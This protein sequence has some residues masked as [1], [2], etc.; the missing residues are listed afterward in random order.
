MGEFEL[1]YQ[2]LVNL[3][4]KQK[5]GFEALIRWNHPERGLI[6]PGDFIPLAEETALIV[7]IGEWV[8]RQ[9]CDEAA[10]WPNHI[11]IAVNLSPAQFKSDRLTQTVINALARSGLSAG[12]T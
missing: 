7:P 10:K 11:S 8:L 1:Y 9:A 2:P 5:T 3:Q 4:T 12:R 6:P